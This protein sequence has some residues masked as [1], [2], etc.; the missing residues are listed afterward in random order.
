MTASS[1]IN[2]MHLWFWILP[3]RWYHLLS[4]GYCHYHHMIY[5][6]KT[7]EIKLGTILQFNLRVEPGPFEIQCKVLS[8]SAD[9]S[10]FLPQDKWILGYLVPCS[11]YFSIYIGF[12]SDWPRIIF[13][14]FQTLLSSL[15][16]KLWFSCEIKSFKSESSIWW[17]DSV[18]RYNST[19]KKLGELIFDCDHHKCNLKNHWFSNNHLHLWLIMIEMKLNRLLLSSF[20]MMN[21]LRD[22]INI[23]ICFVSVL[24]PDRHHRHW[25]L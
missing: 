4:S 22:L 24:A 14:I 8:D 10:N 1:G 6:R 2:S 21:K 7:F 5:F 15:Q 16:S 17:S 25:L 19:E 20:L 3:Q 13:C 11:Q 18:F 9:K 23:Y 12:Y